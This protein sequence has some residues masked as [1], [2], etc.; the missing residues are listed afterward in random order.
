M[1]TMLEP[2]HYGA[3][4]RKR[5]TK[6]LG[7]PPPAALALND[8]NVDLV[9]SLSKL[10]GEEFRNEVL[11]RHAR[12]VAVYQSAQQA[13]ILSGAAI[14]VMNDANLGLGIVLSR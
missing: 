14:P 2:V 9:R 8:A 5:I 1:K 4:G 11:E 7:S 10:S 6:H 3:K 13:N 12:L